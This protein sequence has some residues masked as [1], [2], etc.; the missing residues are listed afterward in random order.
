M[1]R[2]G[3]LFLF[4]VPKSARNIKA[5]GLNAYEYTVND[6]V[7]QA[8]APF[9]IGVSS[10]TLL[11]H[12]LDI[13]D[14]DTL[15]RKTILDNCDWVNRD[16]YL[17][18]PES[19]KTWMMAYDIVENHDKY[20]FL[21]YSEDNGVCHM[22]NTLP[23]KAVKLSESD[24]SLTRLIPGKRNKYK[25]NKHGEDILIDG[26]KLIDL[27]NV[28]VTPGI[29]Y[30]VT[31]DSYDGNQYHVVNNTSVFI[32]KQKAFEQGHPYREMINYLKI[33][34]DR[35]HIIPMKEEL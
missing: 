3:D 17:S 14:S 28:E 13:I 23:K 19:F 32:T 11:G 6:S 18:W 16:R 21:R 22:F 8:K 7:R 2:I 34:K 29:Y 33:W 27:N 12:T 1:I 9:N 35:I 4:E 30:T 24:I 25:K 31:T 10:F 15:I 26:L 20:C 5:I